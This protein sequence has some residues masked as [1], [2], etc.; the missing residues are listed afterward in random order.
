MGHN[1]LKYENLSI[2]K[3]DS[4]SNNK[5]NTTIN[6]LSKSIDKMNENITIQLLNNSTMIVK[7]SER[8]QDEKIENEYMQQDYMFNEQEFHE[9]GSYYNFKE[10][11]EEKENYIFL[12]FQS[13]IERLNVIENNNIEL[14]VTIEDLKTKNIKLN[15]DLDRYKLDVNDLHDKRYTAKNYL[16]I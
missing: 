15:Y 6:K 10:N 13:I 7:A 1:K 8:K 5:V 11:D 14:N 16:K 12:Q 9:D 2:A 3:K 4:R